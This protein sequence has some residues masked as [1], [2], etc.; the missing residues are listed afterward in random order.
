MRNDDYKKRKVVVLNH[1]ADIIGYFDSIKELVEATGYSASS[2][3]KAVRY[4]W[5]YR[6][7]RIVY[8]KEY[9]ERYINGTIE[10]LKF[11]TK[12]ERGVER[13]KKIVQSMSSD[14][15]LKRNKKISDY[16]K[17]KVREDREAPVYKA[18]E[19]AKK[20]VLCIENGNTYP[21]IREA[22][23]SLKIGNSFICAVLKGRKKSAHGLTFKYV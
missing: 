9:R 14:T 18:V 16:W 4:G 6:C 1:K 5:I 7:M 20:P 15:M 13:G 22:G 2:V 10:E 8:E 19:A 21:S 23:R 11:G 3:Y 17:R 12:V